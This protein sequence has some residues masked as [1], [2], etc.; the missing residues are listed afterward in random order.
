MFKKLKPGIMTD[1]LKNISHIY[2]TKT[3]KAN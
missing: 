2:S 3:F 1:K